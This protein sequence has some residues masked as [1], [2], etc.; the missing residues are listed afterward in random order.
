MYFFFLSYFFLGFIFL[1]FFVFFFFCV[2]SSMFFAAYAFWY[3]FWF[4]Y[5]FI[6]IDLNIHF[7]W[8]DILFCFENCFDRN[9]FFRQYCSF[10]E[11]NDLFIEK[12]R[13]EICSVFCFE[14]EAFH[15][16]FLN[17]ELIRFRVFAFSRNRKQKTRLITLNLWKILLI[18][19]VND[20][21]FFSILEIEIVILKIEIRIRFY[22]SR[23]Y[24]Y[25]CDIRFLV[26]FQTVLKKSWCWCF[27]RTKW[28]FFFNF[29]AIALKAQI[30]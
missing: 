19:F 27:H 24:D 17:F 26:Y 30:N 25:K 7:Y 11:T 6:D 8:I 28:C 22:W 13:S 5:F 3:W 14:I 16:L 23:I 18:F 21:I 29:G 1:Y 20:F 9:D 10:S 4:E 12:L 15:R 2:S